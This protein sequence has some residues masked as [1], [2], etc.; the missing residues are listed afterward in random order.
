MLPGFFAFEHPAQ[1]EQRLFLYARYIR[2]R[3]AEH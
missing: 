2:A 3:D 1:V